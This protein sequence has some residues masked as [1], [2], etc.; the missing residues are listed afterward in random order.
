M[1]EII[2]IPQP[3]WI[4]DEEIA[5]LLQKAHETTREAGM[6]FWS[7]DGNAEDN[8][9]RLKGGIFFTA[10]EVP[11]ENAFKET[12]TEE[13]SAGEMLSN[14]TLCGVIG[15]VMHQDKGKQWYNKGV[16]YAELKMAG[17]L[18]E[19][20]G[21]GISNALYKRA[22]DQAFETVDVIIMSTAEQN[23]IVIDSNKRHG[24][25]PV[26]YCSYTNRN[27]YSVFMAKWKE[28]CPFS[29]LYCLTQYTFRKWRTRL[30]FKKGRIRRLG[31]KS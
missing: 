24:W 27:Y 25:V 5:V 22:C 29:S 1:G 26:D 21:R 28:K 17:V 7:S 8:R 10:I 20:R 4:T 3:D 11:E 18:Q 9:R 14:G 23:H 12:N 6:Y 16:P 15:L 13:D 2:V 30:L 31:S 19:Y